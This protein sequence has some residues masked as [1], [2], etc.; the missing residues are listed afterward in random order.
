[1][2]HVKLKMVI[3]TNF[4]CHKNKSNLPS[5]SLRKTEI[6]ALNKSTK[7]SQHTSSLSSCHIRWTYHCQHVDTRLS[8][9]IIWWLCLWCLPLICEITTW[10]APG[11]DLIWD[12]YW[13][14]SNT[15]LLNNSTEHRTG[16]SVRGCWKQDQ[17]LA[18]QLS[19]YIYRKQIVS[20]SLESFLFWQNR[21]KEGLVP[22]SQEEADTRIMIWSMK[23]TD[24]AFNAITIQSFDS[25]VVVLAMRS[26]CSVGRFHCNS[27]TVTHVSI[28]TVQSDCLI[29]SEY[30]SYQPPKRWIFLP[31]V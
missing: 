31:E 28:Y 21:S 23:Q 15:L 4:F 10:K 30:I 17:L 29:H 19:S 6:N 9:K 22:S 14:G 8:R 1:M 11:V 25:E 13:Q 18:I 16:E 3:K 20:T 7:E 2:W 5:L 27:C 24:K 26:Y 12:D